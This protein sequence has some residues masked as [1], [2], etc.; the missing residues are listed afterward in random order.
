MDQSIT[1]ETPENV[2]IE[3]ELAGL[4]TRF[5]AWVTDQLLMLILWLA[6]FM[7]MMFLFA[8]APDR[9]FEMFLPGAD[10]ASEGQVIAY[11]I[12]VFLLILGL[13][14]F[15]YFG[16]FELFMRGQTPGK[17]SAGIRVVKLDGFALDGT[18][19]LV[20]NL[21]R[22]VDQIPLLWIV[23]ALSQRQQRLGDMVAGTLLVRDGRKPDDAGGLREYIQA[24]AERRGESPFNF[25]G[26]LM[27]L[28]AGDWHAVEATLDRML[29]SG[30]ESCAKPAEALTRA[31]ACK[32]DV[33][34][35]AET[36]RIEFLAELLTAEYRRRER[37]LG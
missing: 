26:R 20:R 21:F 25:R 27:R 31:L 4:G 28:D 33:P 12:G 22:V 9:M 1:F 32:L 13:G 8:V 36:E 2:K 15:V 11:A 29:R 34:V 35:P 23:P 7:I 19:I 10:E 37:Q 16:L 3:Y 24:R 17:R 14:N 18:G 30:T 5:V 6:I